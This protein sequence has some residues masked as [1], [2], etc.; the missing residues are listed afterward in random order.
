V[1]VNLLSNAAK[2]TAGGEVAIDIT[3]PIGNTCGCA[4]RHRVASLPS[5]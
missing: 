3:R 1:L 5:A 2:Y 4:S